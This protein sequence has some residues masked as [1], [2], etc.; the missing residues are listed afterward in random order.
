MAGYKIAMENG[1][2]EVKAKADMMAPNASEDG[3]ATALKNLFL[4][5]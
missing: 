3:L 1:S 2:D 5:Q 4:R